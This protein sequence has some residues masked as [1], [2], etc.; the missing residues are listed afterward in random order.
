[1]PT[2]AEVAK[3]WVNP[4]AEY[5]PEPYFGMNGPVTIESLAHDL[6]TMKSL[7]FHAVT[8]QA[9]GGMTTTYLSPEYFAFFKQFALEAK[10]R[11]MKVWIVDDIGYP[12]G[13]AGGIF[14]KDHHDLSMQALS[15]GQRFPV[16]A[17]ETLNQ[18]VS[19]NAVA[20]IATSASGERVAVPINNGAISWTAPAGS[21]Y[22][23][24]V[25]EHVF[26][27]SPT[28]SDTNPTHAKDSTQPLEDYLN[29]AATAAYLEAT[30]NGYYRAMPE[31]F[32][33]TILGFRGDEPDYS[34][35]GL[36]WTPAFFDTFQKVKGY[37]IRPY[38]AAILSSQGGGGRPRPAPG[39]APRRPDDHAYR[40]P[41]THR[42]RTSRQGRLLRRLLPDV[43][44]RLL[45]TAGHLVR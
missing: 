44:R 34:I 42:R 8:A 17:G 33:T 38:L 30:H 22:T 7:G 2:V 3:V 23:V 36:P 25:V 12:S 43:P 10:K 45:Q 41:Q 31:L 35:A 21:D 24:A 29:P 19:A 27:T 37:D 9:G 28:K 13:F 39:A 18:T 32:G 40:A 1:M 15:L 11:D 6:D 20:A 5:G 16:K 4:P 14:A 26:R